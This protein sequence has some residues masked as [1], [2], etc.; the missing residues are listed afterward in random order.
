MKKKLISF[1]VLLFIA[2]TFSLAEEMHNFSEAE[3]IITNKIPCSELTEDK[4][5]L[6]GDYYMEQMHPGEA[7]EVMDEMMG[8]EDSESLRQ[9]H[10]NMGKSFYCGETSAVPYGMMGRGMMMGQQYYNDK[11][12]KGGYHMNGMMWGSGGS[13]GMGFWWLVQVAI[14]AFIFG[15]IFWWTKKLI[16]KK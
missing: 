11:N 2:S 16:F 10:I 1:F 13:F 7:H 6:L 12:Y 15:I 8:G 3:D 5:E 14:A 9:M 4:L